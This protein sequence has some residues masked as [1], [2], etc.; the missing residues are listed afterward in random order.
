M[1]LNA[2]RALYIFFSTFIYGSS[3][4]CLLSACLTADVLIELNAFSLYVKA[5]HD[6]LLYSADMF[7]CLA[8]D[9]DV[10]NC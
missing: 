10:V 9:V 5:L 2:C 3:Q 7:D 6:G 4:P 8:D 1:E